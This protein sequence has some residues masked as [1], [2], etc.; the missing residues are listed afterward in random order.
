VARIY[1]TVTVGESMRWPI[2]VTDDF[3]NLSKPVGG[4]VHQPV[5]ND[6]GRFVG[7]TMRR[8]YGGH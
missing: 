5:T 8:S 7:W 1:P 6:F 3:G 2:G 4:M